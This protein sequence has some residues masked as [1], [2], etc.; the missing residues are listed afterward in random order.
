MIDAS[1]IDVT[2]GV[3]IGSE[4]DS[5]PNEGES[6]TGNEL[7]GCT[8]M[9][10]ITLR[11]MIT[12]AAIICLRRG[13]RVSTKLSCCGWLLDCSITIYTLYANILDRPE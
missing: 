7:C 9:D 2:A 10:R 3:A 13:R 11:A 4:G 6:D 8:R 5:I 12:T 1:G